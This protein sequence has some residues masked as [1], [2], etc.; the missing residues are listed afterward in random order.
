MPYKMKGHGSLF[1]LTFWRSAR[2]K[3]CKHKEQAK[4]NMAEEDSTTRDTSSSSLSN[5]NRGSSF[6]SSIFRRTVSLSE[7]TNE[8]EI[9]THTTPG[10]L[11]GFSESSLSDFDDDDAL[12]IHGND[13][14]RLHHRTTTD[15]TD[16]NSSSFANPQRQRSLSLS[17]LLLGQHNLPD[18]STGINASTVI[19]AAATEDN[20]SDNSQSRETTQ[21]DHLNKKL[22]D[23]FLTRINSMASNIFD[24]T[25]TGDTSGQVYTD[26]VMMD[27]IL[28]RI[29]SNPNNKK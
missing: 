8:A 2:S 26:D 11:R 19:E 6:I 17:G 22:L 12:T 5:R 7:S 29:D 23:S 15:T 14:N 9:V 13:V 25:G 3:V 24:P 27:R 18:V 20:N 16:G 1:C 10:R 21:T 28:R 4:Q